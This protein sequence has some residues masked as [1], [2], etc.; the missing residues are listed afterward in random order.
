MRW[1]GHIAQ[2]GE[3]RNMH[4]V[5]EVKP[6]EKRSLRRSRCR[7]FTHTVVLELTWI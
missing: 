5:L 2:V 6:E 7:Y 3:K 1:P 4:K